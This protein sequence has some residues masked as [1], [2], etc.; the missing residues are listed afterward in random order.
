MI[1][2]YVDC[3]PREETFLSRQKNLSISFEK[4]RDNDRFQ[5]FIVVDWA[6][7]FDEVDGWAT[8][9][10]QSYMW[11]GDQFT[12]KLSVDGRPT[13]SKIIY[14]WATCLNKSPNRFKN[15]SVGRPNLKLQV[16]ATKIK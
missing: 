8:N 5:G 15:K 2:A 11:L 14:G 9:L 16:Q 12:P 1:A 13:Y 4:M 7:Y 10:L 3:R 6:T